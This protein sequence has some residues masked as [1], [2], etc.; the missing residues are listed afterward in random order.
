MPHLYHRAEKQR[1]SGSIE[2]ISGNISA[3]SKNNVVSDDW[4]K[5]IYTLM[6]ARKRAEAIGM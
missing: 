5:R 3:Y 4:Q 1:E 2:Y 6:R